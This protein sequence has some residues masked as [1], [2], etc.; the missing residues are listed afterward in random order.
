MAQ[1]IVGKDEPLESAIRRFKKKVEA[2]GIIKSFKEKQFFVKPSAKKREKRKEALRKLM[3]K[4]IRK[5]KR[6]YDATKRG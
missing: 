3:V 6:V 2:E 4:K 5:N 1:I